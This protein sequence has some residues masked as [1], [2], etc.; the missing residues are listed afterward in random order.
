MPRTARELV[1]NGVYHVML[2]GHNRVKLF[3]AREDY[4]RFLSTV[5]RYKREIPF[6]LYHYCLMPNHVHLLIKI[7]AAGD[8]PK[9]MSRVSLSFSHYSR[10]VYGR[11]GYIFQGRYKSLHIEDD[12]Y[13]LDCGRYIE[14]NPVR[15][16]IVRDAADYKWSS[17]N[18]YAYNAQ[19]RL[20]TPNPLYAELDTG[21]QKR[22]KLYRGYIKT[23]R[24]YE[25]LIDEALGLS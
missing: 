7:S 20:L 16:E 22:Q 2:R 5:S 3:E 13:L 25:I 10:R 8:L 14:R 12:S 18:F 17:F 1:D 4:Q 23:P 19:N 6:H 21:I 15:A 11:V 9:L 24:N